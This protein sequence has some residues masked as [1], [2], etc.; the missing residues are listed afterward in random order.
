MDDFFKSWR[1]RVGVITLV[2]ACVFVAGWV[3]SLRVSD[4]VTMHIVVDRIRGQD[5]VSAVYLHTVPNYLLFRRTCQAIGNVPASKW[6]KH[7]KIPTLSLGGPTQT[8]EEFISSKGHWS[9]GLIGT[10]TPRSLV[11]P[12][13]KLDWVY[14]IP[15]WSIVVPLTL[16]STWLMLSRPRAKKAGPI[17][18]SPAVIQS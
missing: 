3:R 4:L 7:L 2:L 16:L 9:L 15:Y 6:I 13:G 14:A 10:D 8:L 18:K 11:N 5:A 1:R 17:P 12:N